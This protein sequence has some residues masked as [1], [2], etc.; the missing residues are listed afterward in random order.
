MASLKAASQ[1]VP[2]VSLVMRIWPP[3]GLVVGI[4]A[5][6]AWSLF[7]VY[8]VLVLIGLVS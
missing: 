8:L 7:L 1:L 2:S 6:I 3:V 5:T 4:A